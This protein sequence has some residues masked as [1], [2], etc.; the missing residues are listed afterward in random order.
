M[1]IFLIACVVSFIPFVAIYLWLRKRVKDEDYRKLCSKAMLKGILSSI[2]VLVVSGVLC[3][4]LAL[5][6]LKDAHPILYMAI[7]EFIGVAFAEEIVKFLTFRSVLKRNNYP[8]SWFDAV[9]LMTIV[10]TGFGLLEAV[11]YAIGASIPVVLVRGICMPHVGYGYLTGYFYGKG[12]KK[13]SKFTQWLGFIIAWL[14]HGLYDFTLS[15]QV[16]ALNE[17]V[18][19]VPFILA[20][21]DIVL[22]FRLIR[23]IKKAR[24]NET[25]TAPFFRKTTEI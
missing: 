14:L 8:Y 18:M 12:V 25:Y 13:G 10:G 11:V 6:S 19:F 21:T 24:N 2:P 7:R 22:V 4:A 1:L 20:I 17:Y 15:E 16:M 9:V 23:F 5:T 3:T